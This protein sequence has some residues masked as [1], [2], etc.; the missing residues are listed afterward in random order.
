[1]NSQ[2]LQGLTILLGLCALVVLVVLI[3]A[4]VRFFTV[5][6]RGTSILLRQ[7]PSKDSHSWRH[8][9][10]RYDGEYMDYFKLRSVMPRAN[11][12]FNR[13]DIELGKTRPMDDDEAS[14]C[15]QVTKSSSFASMVGTMKLPPMRRASWP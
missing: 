1:M 5:R 3:L 13:L 7:L 15:L 9:L 2:V 14:L 10:V 12:R 8:G 4:A 11:Q 6:S